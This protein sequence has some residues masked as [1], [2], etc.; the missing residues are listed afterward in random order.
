LEAELKRKFNQK[1]ISV[2]D[3]MDHVFRVST[4]TYAGT[5]HADDIALFHDGLSAWW[6]AGALAHMKALGFEHRKIRNITA[7]KESRYEGKIVGDSPEMC[8]A[9]DSTVSLT[10][11]PRLW[12]T[13]LTL[14]S[15]L[16]AMRTVSTWARRTNCSAPLREPSLGNFQLQDL[17]LEVSKLPRKFSNR[18]RNVPEGSFCFCV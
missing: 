10:L 8:R 7:N 5:V 17:A 4:E 3:L 2:T 12:P 11:R 18:S 15:F 13:P 9:L 1:I 16:L 14:L 6:E